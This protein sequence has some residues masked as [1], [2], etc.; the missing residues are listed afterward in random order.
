MMSIDFFYTFVRA[1][2][3]SET[4]EF[5]FQDHPCDTYRLKKCFVIASFC[6]PCRIEIAYQCGKLVL[7]TCIVIVVKWLHKGFI[8]SLCKVFPKDVCA[9]LFP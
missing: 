8:K 2:V 3:S 1:F 7:F 5:V 6:I 4:F 9:K